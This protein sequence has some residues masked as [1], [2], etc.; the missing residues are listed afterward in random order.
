MSTPQ[1]PHVNDNPSGPEGKAQLIKFLQSKP[2]QPP[3]K[4]LTH[5]EL[6]ARV[7]D[8]HVRGELVEGLIPERSVNIAIGDSGLGK[9]PLLVQLGLCVASEGGWSE[10]ELQKAEASNFIAVRLGSRI[11]RSETAGIAA[12]TLAQHLFGDLR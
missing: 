5:A 3:F 7:A 11:L 12:V 9:T 8:A 10:R 4:S 6:K 1:V 2:K